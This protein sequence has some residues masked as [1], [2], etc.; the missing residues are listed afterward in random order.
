M[1]LVVI[2]GVVF[3]AFNATRST[4]G[5]FQRYVAHGQTMRESRFALFLTDYYENGQTWDGVQPLVTQLAAMSGERIVLADVKGVVVADSEQT[6]IGKTLGSNSSTKI[7]SSDGATVGYVYFNPLVDAQTSITDY[8][9]SVTRSVWVGALIAIAIAFLVTLLL[10]RRILQPVEE[11]TAAVRKMQKGDLSVRVKVA[12]IDEVGQLSNSF[13]AMA[14]SLAKQEQLRKNM[15]NDVAHELRTP[16]SNIRGYLEAARD[17]IVEPGPDWVNNLFDEAL[18][19]NRLIEDLQELAQADAGRISIELAAVN[20]GQVIQSTVDNLLP[21]SQ[22]LGLE[23]TCE[24]PADLPDVT[25]DPQR[26]GQ[27]LRNLINNALD[28][29]PASGRIT[30]QARAEGAFI[31][32]AVMDTGYGIASEHLPFLFER[33]YRADPSRSRSTGGAG[34]GLAIVKQLVQ[35]QGGQVGVESNPG[36]GST[37]YF[38][39][40]VSPQN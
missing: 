20:L 36:T 19:L 3:T 25:A 10:S 4:T 40:P 28:Y 30:I 34:L 14:D 8:L 38:T 5:E 9:A 6:L 7:T 16:L 18:L 27:V 24:I 12:D 39:L 1:V 2:A 15:V 29:T 13:N 23:M 22:K 21:I 26:I 32:V 37:F 33:F 17:G 31:R 11:L 35:A